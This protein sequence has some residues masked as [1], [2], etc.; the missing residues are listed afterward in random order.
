MQEDEAEQ[1]A[2]QTQKS[3]LT[4]EKVKDNDQIL[5]VLGD[6]TD[7]KIEIILLLVFLFKLLFKVDLGFDG[8]DLDFKGE[9][10]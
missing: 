4:R 7:S 9:P 3:E 8:K 1:F 6:E 10:F 2:I 5:Q